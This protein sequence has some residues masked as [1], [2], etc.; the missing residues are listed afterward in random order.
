MY[1]IAIQKN[2]T[3]ETRIAT[4]NADWCDSSYFFLTRGNYGCDCNRELE[5]ERANGI[6]IKNEH[7]SHDRFSIL[8]AELEDGS[9]IQIDDKD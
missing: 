5:F 9:K 4:I 3:K 7:C 2:E 1:K 6:E 8:Y